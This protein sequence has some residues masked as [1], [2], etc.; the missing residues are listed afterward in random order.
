[1]SADALAT[2]GARASVGMALIPTAVVFHLQYQKSL[3]QRLYNHDH[4]N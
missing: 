3:E 4:D 2:L 1:M